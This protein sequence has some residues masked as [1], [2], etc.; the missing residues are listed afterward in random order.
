MSRRRQKSAWWG[1][2]LVLLCVVGLLGSVMWW[3]MRGSSFLIDRPAIE[4]AV[5]KRYLPIGGD[6]LFSLRTGEGL[7]FKLTSRELTCGSAPDVYLGIGERFSCSASEGMQKEFGSPRHGWP[8]EAKVHFEIQEKQQAL[9]LALRGYSFTPRVEGVT[10]GIGKDADFVWEAPGVGVEHVSFLPP[11]VCGQEHTSGLCIRNGGLGGSVVLV[12]STEKSDMR[13]VALKHGEA[14]LAAAGDWLWLGQVPLELSQREDAWSVLLPD[15]AWGK[16][17]G[18]RRWMSLETPK[19]FLG[20]LEDK[21]QGEATKKVF[22]SDQHEQL[23]FYSREQLFRTPQLGRVEHLRDYRYEYQQE[24]RYQGFIDHELLCFAPTPPEASR[25]TPALGRFFWNLDTGRGC[26][27]E[28]PVL[29]PPAD[30]L[31]QATLFQGD[32]AVNAHLDKVL[33]LLGQTPTEAATPNEMLFVFDW[34]YQ[35]PEQG[36]LPECTERNAIGRESTW[37]CLQPRQMDRVPVRLLGVRPNATRS[38]PP[39]ESTLAARA[40]ESLCSQSKALDSVKPNLFVQQGSTSPYL[41]VEK[42]FGLGVEPGTRLLIQASSQVGHTGLC[43]AAQAG[44]PENFKGTHLLGQIRLGKK[45]LIDTS[46]RDLTAISNEACALFT[47]HEGGWQLSRAGSAGSVEFA[48]NLGVRQPAADFR[49]PGTPLADQGTLTL[50]LGI[51][52]LVLTLHLPDRLDGASV[53]EISEEQATRSYPFGEDMGPLLGGPIWGGLETTLQ[54]EQKVEARKKMK[55]D[56]GA[57]N[58]EAVPGVELTVRGDLQRLIY[59][60]LNQRKRNADDDSASGQAV[61]MDGKTGAILAAASAPSFHPEHDVQQI[62]RQIRMHGGNWNPADRYQNLA[63]R[64]TNQAGSVY[65]LITT[66]GMLQRGL[67]DSQAERYVQPEPGCGKVLSYRQVPGAIDPETGIQAP[68]TL[69]PD[70]PPEALAADRGRYGGY[71]AQCDWDSR[72]ATPWTS[73][74]A[75]R[76]FNQAFVKSVNAYFAL[77]FVASIEELGLGFTPLQTH[78]WRGGVDPVSGT[79]R[80]PI[81]RSSGSNHLVL[82]FPPE[83]TANGLGALLSDPQK[84]KALNALIETGHRFVGPGIY[85]SDRGYRLGDVEVT[86]PTADVSDRRWLPGVSGAAFQYPG[87]PAWFAASFADDDRP[88]RVPLT[89]IRADDARE[90]RDF[91]GNPKTGSAQQSWGI[92]TPRI[93]NV[94]KN[95][96]GYGGIQA[97]ALSLA[98]MTTPMA[99]PDRGVVTPHILSSTVPD[100]GDAAG[101]AMFDRAGAQILEAAMRGVVSSENGTAVEYFRYNP[102]RQKIGGKTGTYEI[103]APLAVRD[104]VGN[105]SDRALRARVRGY[106]C[107]VRGLDVGPTD[108]KRLETVVNARNIRRKAE[109][110]LVSEVLTRVNAG[111]L[112][113]KPG[114]GASASTCDVLNPNRPQVGQN[115]GTDD[116]GLDGGVWLEA[117]DSLFEAYRPEPQLLKSGA[118]VSVAF[119]PLLDSAPETEGWVLAVLF[120]RDEFGAKKVA[121]K[122]WESLYHYVEIQQLNVQ[123]AAT[124]EVP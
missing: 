54:S 42:A 61:L 80:A 64:R 97:S 77:G 31:Q 44:G 102:V 81:W 88:G 76:G 49:E 20:R 14:V 100:A 122:I 35:L 98:V 24:E 91:D 58:S 67:L 19:Y 123:S 36:E 27:R 117:L 40:G 13:G 84:N 89:L 1:L 119:D 87:I 10:L 33:E 37:K 29:P 90:T 65:K 39:S 69:F 116:G 110:R 85:G 72:R 53:L 45:G 9:K 22:A 12:Q 7:R 32:K 55:R 111:E 121:N 108:W 11:S 101:S 63:F 34:A 73:S 82:N 17:D 79:S 86:Y 120:D 68:T 70:A 109:K 104:R 105:V 16:R 56:C 38:A 107:G 8:A 78:P 95:S 124:P 92:E 99:H 74:D 83:A 114:F 59:D 46:R 5:G 4:D 43:L 96:F 21:D 2:V 28:T 71:G 18:D 26:D 52:K 62:Q 47:R 103:A 41:E 25:K 66:Y 30:L 15:E 112:D 113:L 93:S 57:E 3:T 23:A 60:A 94:L 6:H 115:L 51:T 48:P 118:F 106:A 75:S 50:Q